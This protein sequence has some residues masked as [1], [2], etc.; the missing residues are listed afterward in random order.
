[1]NRCLAW[2]TPIAVVGLILSGCSNESSSS[3][4]ETTSAT[5]TASETTGAAPA[6]DLAVLDKA[7]ADYKAYAQS[8][9]D[10]LQRVVKVF[11]DAVRA[12]DLKAA[13]DAYAPS[14]QP[15]ER[16]EPIAG[17]VEEIDVKI[18]ARV[19]DFAGVD[20][21]KFTGWHRL[22][23]LLFEKNTT[24]GGAPFADQLD[25]DVADLKAQFPA[26]EVKPI[27][28]SNG[29]AEL[30]EEVSEGKITGEE[31][32]YSKTDL[33]D[34]DAN[35]QGSR[36]AVNTLSA[37][38]VQADPA[39]LGK[40]EA[41]LN[42]V[43]DTMRPLRRGDGWVLFCTENDPYPSPRCPEVTVTPDVIDKLKAELA[44]LSENL[45]QVS[46]VLKLK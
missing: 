3:G 16:I 23:Y 32:R 25:K 46:G 38:L 26:V 45:S 15:W 4:S 7:A 9:I 41:G 43:F 36:D 28:V 13:Q 39:L 29:A 12:G 35:L 10:E 2:A 1:M 11:T 24:E 21:P 20:D 6:V 37:A 18:D 19:D 27:D 44:G 34:F 31:D 22:E 5:G 17:L 14:R 40:I 8:N 42:S 33:W 30:I